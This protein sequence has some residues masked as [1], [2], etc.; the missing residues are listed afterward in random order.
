MQVHVL[1]EK[2]LVL[3]K[4][5]YVLCIVNVKA[6]LRLVFGEKAVFMDENYTSYNVDE[7]CHSMSSL[8]KRVIRTP[9]KS[10]VVPEIIR[11][12]EFD[13]IMNRPVNLTRQNIFIRDDFICQYCGDNKK[14]TVDHII[15]KSRAKEHFMTMQQINAWENVIT[16]CEPCNI[17]KDNKTP[18]EAGIKLMSEPTRPRHT[19]FG[20]DGKNIKDTWK[21]YVK[22]IIE[23]KG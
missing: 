22:G 23:D 5:Y 8:G 6:A 13:K 4:N 20:F 3:N 18:K 1:N 9:Q 7:W 21:P 16:C 14:L 15:P 11:L 12:T 19:I 2:V 17:K 10:F